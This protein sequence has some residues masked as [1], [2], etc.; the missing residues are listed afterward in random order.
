ML[1]TVLWWWGVGLGAVGAAIMTVGLLV[2][3][4]HLVWKLVVH[5]HGLPIVLF[6][7]REHNRLKEQSNANKS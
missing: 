3:L 4:L 2:L 7:L 5:I 1:M 6:A